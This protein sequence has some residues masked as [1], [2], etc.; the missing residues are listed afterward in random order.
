MPNCANKL[1]RTLKFLLAGL[2]FFGGVLGI[3]GLVGFSRSI[4]L[5]PKESVLPVLFGLELLFLFLGYS[6]LEKK[7]LSQNSDCAQGSGVVEGLSF[8]PEETQRER[9]AQE[10]ARQ[11]W[12]A[13]EASGSHLWTMQVLPEASGESGEALV[14]LSWIGSQVSLNFPEDS[15]FRFFVNG[16][17]L[18][19]ATKRE[20]LSAIYECEEYLEKRRMFRWPPDAEEIALL[21][22][23]EIEETDGVCFPNPFPLPPKPQ[24]A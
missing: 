16:V 7:L 1:T 9:V 20:C 3:A 17:F 13:A 14:G 21:I 18:G 4:G 23:G 5:L 10:E 22:R 19:R 12:A 6:F 24:E 8:S 11:K 15:H 2:L